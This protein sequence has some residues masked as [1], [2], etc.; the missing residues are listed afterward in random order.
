MGSCGLNSWG[1]EQKPVEGLFWT[2]VA[3]LRALQNVGSFYYMSD[4]QLLKEN[5]VHAGNELISY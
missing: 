1:L 3:K 4:Y 2:S 5:S